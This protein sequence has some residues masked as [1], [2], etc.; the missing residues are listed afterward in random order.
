MSERCKTYMP[1]CVDDAS[2]RAR[3]A[4][5]DVTPRVPH[6]RQ[7][8]HACRMRARV[9]MITPAR[10][11]PASRYDILMIMR[12]AVTLPSRCCCARSAASA[13]HTPRKIR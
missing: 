3:A 4:R 8:R 12:C 2:Q 13:Q 10:V 9:T 7:R 6:A 11:T 5:R 1:R